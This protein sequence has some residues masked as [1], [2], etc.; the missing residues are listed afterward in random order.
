MFTTTSLTVEKFPQ[1]RRF[2][3]K[4]RKFLDSERYK[5]I[6]PVLALALVLTGC[7]TSGTADPPEPST[8]SDTAPEVGFPADAV[9]GVSMPQKTSQSWVPAEGMFRDGLKDAGFTPKVSFADGGVIEQQNQIQAM[10]DAGAKVIIV[11]PINGS[12]LG[13][14]LAAAKQAGIT[15]IAYERLLKNTPNVDAYIAYDYCQEGRAQGTALLEGLAKKGHGPYN[16]ELIAGWPDDVDYAPPLFNCAMEVLQPKID[17]GTLKVP[18]GQLTQAQVGTD[19]WL[20]TNAKKRL[21]SILSDF[22][23]NGTLLD[24]V[25]SPNDTLA[26]TAI[27][28]AEEAGLSIPVVTGRDSEE[29]SIRSIADGKQYS[30]IY[31]DDF[32]LVTETISI[33]KQLQQGQEIAFTDTTTYDNG[34]KIVPAYL[35]PAVIVT[36]DNI[37]TAYPFDTAPGKAAAATPLCKGE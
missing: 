19:G 32:T 1:N 17:D 3:P 16:I 8:P 21:D 35:L 14:Q 9:I 15:V 29:E 26:R 23:S 6:V 31:Q 36:Q 4:N 2:W 28:A 34:V 20:A 5:L 11:S 24:G 22:Y 27:T 13:E 18:S 30:T 25:L 33:V 7:T 37:C 10:I 12:Q